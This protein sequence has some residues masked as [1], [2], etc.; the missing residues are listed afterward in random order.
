MTSNICQILSTKKV[1]ITL[2][3]FDKAHKKL[4]KVSFSHNMKI[5]KSLKSKIEMCPS[6]ILLC[7]TQIFNF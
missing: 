5:E 6:D 4:V 3:S 7:I 2:T 1:E